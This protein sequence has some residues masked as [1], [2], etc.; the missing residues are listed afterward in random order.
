MPSARP[1]VSNTSSTYEMQCSDNRILVRNYEI[2]G[3]VSQITLNGQIMGISAVPM[4]LNYV[5]DASIRNWL[6]DSFRK[7]QENIL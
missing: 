1:F 3:M 2:D 4:R 6:Y 5:E 7:D